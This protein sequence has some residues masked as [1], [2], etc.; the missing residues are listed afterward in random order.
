M[1]MIFVPSVA[2]TV[3]LGAAS[4]RGRRGPPLSGRMSRMIAIAGA[5]AGISVVTSAS[6]ITAQETGEGTQAA[7][8]H[9]SAQVCAPSSSDR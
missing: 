3:L 4:A 7:R 5:F 9:H 8:P 2:G 6:L 1:N